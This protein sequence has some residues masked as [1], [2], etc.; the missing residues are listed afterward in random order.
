MRSALCRSFD[1]A[2]FRTGRLLKVRKG[3]VLFRVGVGGQAWDEQPSLPG[4]QGHS[5]S[6]ISFEARDAYRAET[7]DM[8]H[9]TKGSR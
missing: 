9:T 8:R 5:W 6:Q 3:R 4:V 1:V 7:H 2:C